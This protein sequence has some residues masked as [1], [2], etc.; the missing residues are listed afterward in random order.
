MT[1][2]LLLALGAVG[3]LISYALSRLVQ[4]GGRRLGAV[5]PP[6]SDRWHRT[7]TP[8]FGGVAVALTALYLLGVVVVL[9]PGIEGMTIALTVG[10][11]AFAMFIVG[12]ADDTLALTPLGKL[13]ASL[14]I[15]AFYVFGL[16]AATPQASPHTV[17]AIV[18]IIWFGGIVHALNLLDNM[19]GLAAGVGVVACLFFAWAYPVEL[20]P[21]LVVLLVAVSGSLLGFLIWNRPPAR[22]FMGD[23][24]SLFV[25][26]I[27]AGSS[28]VPFLAHEP[29]PVLDVLAVG[30][31]LSVPLFDTGF[32]LVL[33]RLAGRKATRGGTD[34]VSHR[35]ASLGF[36][37]RSTVRILYG[38]GIAGGALAVGLRAAREDGLV[39]IAGLFVVA[40]AI[41]PA[42]PPTKRTTSSRCRRA[43][44][45]RS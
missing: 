40:T 42:C 45:P 33:R 23:C 32:V 30:L 29:N 7:A 44:S 28:L 27:L 19:D 39:P 12:L 16:I 35:L 21:A 18:A 4:R 10:A 22:L 38:L 41:W 3:V 20:G 8:T 14:V 15:G 36:S 2:T 9:V 25:G 43:P 6:R 37:E 24:G 5:V 26:A 1:L 31:I 11:A 34:H 17:W 13:V